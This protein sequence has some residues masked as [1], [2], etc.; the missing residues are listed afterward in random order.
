MT[1]PASENRPSIAATVVSLAA[2]AG[3]LETRAVELRQ[4]LADLDE[5]MRA[6]SNRLRQNRRSAVLPGTTSSEGL[7][8]D[9]NSDYSTVTH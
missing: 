9:N 2:E 1:T 5:Q 8:D 3:A 7:S 4:A 6:V